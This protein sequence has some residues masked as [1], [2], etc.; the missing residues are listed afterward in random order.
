M[1]E[2]SMHGELL[3]TG[4]SF[5]AKRLRWDEQTNVIQAESITY[6]GPR[7][8]VNGE[9]MRITLPTGVVEFTGPVTSTIN[10]NAAQ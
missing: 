6:F 3:G 7:L 9:A 10:A 2:G 8:V 4:Q 5:D 1:V